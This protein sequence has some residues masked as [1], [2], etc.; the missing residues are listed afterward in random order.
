MARK[1]NTSINDR[2]LEYERQ[3]FIKFG[4]SLRHPIIL[5]VTA[6]DFESFAAENNVERFEDER[7][8]GTMSTAAYNCASSHIE[9]CVACFVTFDAAYFC[10][11][12]N[13]KCR[14][15]SDF[16]STAASLMTLEFNCLF[17]GRCSLLFTSKMVELPNLFEVKNYF[18]WRQIKHLRSTVYNFFNKNNISAPSDDKNRIVAFSE[19]LAIAQNHKN[20]AN[21]REEQISGVFVRQI[22]T[23]ELRRN[24][25]ANIAPMFNT[26]DGADFMRD[27]L[28]FSDL[29]HYG[30]KP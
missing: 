26:D 3:S 25:V 13:N 10:I 9:G 7:L 20:W 2:M 8:F 11:A 14:N 6:K 1:I 22:E 16:V 30:E 23:S 24:W 19:L 15:Y 29:E 18:I 4:N 17:Q 28:S 27:A 12:N 21:L 5:C